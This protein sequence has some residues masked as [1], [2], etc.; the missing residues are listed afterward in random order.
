MKY[1]SESHANSSVKI[2]KHDFKVDAK[3]FIE[4][5]SIKDADEKKDFLTR[6]A[7]SGF[8]KF[9]E[10]KHGEAPAVIEE[11]E[12]E[13]EVIEEIKEDPKEDIAEEQEPEEDK[14][15]FARGKNKGKNK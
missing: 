8:E 11:T 14:P 6:L 10:K 7:I 3:G 2:G 5:P 13:A 12:A 9:N 1:V 4:I 15:K